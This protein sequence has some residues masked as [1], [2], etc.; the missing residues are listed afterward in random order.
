MIFSKPSVP[1]RAALLQRARLKLCANLQDTYCVLHLRLD[2]EDNEIPKK[3]FPSPSSI[4]ISNAFLD[5][6]T[7]G[8]DTEHFCETEESMTTGS[9][10]KERALTKLRCPATITLFNLY[11]TNLGPLGETNLAQATQQPV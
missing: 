9:G 11:A 3:T 1:P 7:S 10:L 2:R 4:S 6:G 5:L 8:A